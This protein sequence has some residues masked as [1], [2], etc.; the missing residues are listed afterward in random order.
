MTRGYDQPLWELAP[1]NGR[2]A[3][4]QA[5]YYGY[6]SAKDLAAKLPE[7]AN[8]IDVGTGIADFPRVIATERSDT[9]V[10]C[11]DLRFDNPTILEQAMGNNTPPNL[12]Y[13]TGDILNIEES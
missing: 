8:V 6:P 13:V 2:D 1:T 3:D 4:C 10:T 9:T 12:S 11:L 7:E 5:R